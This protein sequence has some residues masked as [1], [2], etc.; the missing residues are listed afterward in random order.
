MKIYIVEKFDW[1]EYGTGRCSYY[2][3]TKEKAEAYVKKHQQEKEEYIKNFQDCGL[4]FILSEAI[5]DEFE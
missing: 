1:N 4:E 5:L 3:S 2:F